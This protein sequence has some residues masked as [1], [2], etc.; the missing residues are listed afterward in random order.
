VLAEK[1]N[2]R[3]MVVPSPWLLPTP[4]VCEAVSSEPAVRRYLEMAQ[5]ADLGLV[6]LGS[7]DPSHSTI[8]RNQLITLE[9]LNAYRAAGAVGETC[10]KHFNRDGETLDIEFNKRTVSI[11]LEDLSKIDT[12]IGV[13]ASIYKVDPLLGA[14]R[15]GLINVVITDS[16]AAR[17]MLARD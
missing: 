15:G 14:M 8:L 17:A 1:V 16:D 9:E 5:Q 3:A 7:M 6:G 2:G 13:A 10:G 11:S 4:E 12:V